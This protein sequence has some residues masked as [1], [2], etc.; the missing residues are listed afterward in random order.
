MLRNLSKQ[1]KLENPCSVIA[2]HGTG[3]LIHGA[4][5]QMKPAHWLAVP[6]AR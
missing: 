6:R 5:M 3:N 4:P 2:A 1:N